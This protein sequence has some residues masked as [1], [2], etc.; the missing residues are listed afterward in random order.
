MK[1]LYCIAYNASSKDLDVKF[2]VDKVDGEYVISLER[3]DGKAKLVFDGD[4][5][6]KY[7]RGF[8]REAISRY[9]DYIY[10][11]L[12]AMKQFYKKK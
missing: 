1:K 2:F 3:T 4:G 10:D 12:D 7:N 11:K 6:E 5:R 9:Q 8:D